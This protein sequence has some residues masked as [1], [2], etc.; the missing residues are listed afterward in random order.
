MPSGI[1]KPMREDAAAYVEH[2]YCMHMTPSRSLPDQLLSTADRA[3]R[4]LFAPARAARPAPGL[5]GAIPV[6]TERRLAAGLMRV[7]HAGEIAAQGLY[8]GQALV[9]R[10]PAIRQLLEKASRE[11]TDHLAWCE[12]R[13]REL[14]D[15]PSRL[16]PLWYAGSFA[17]GVAAGLA[18]DR[19]S[20]GFVAETERQVERHLDTHL[21]QLPATD[22]RSRAIIT[23]MRA[24]E[25][26]HGDLALESGGASLPIPVQ[27]LMQA[28]ARVMTTTSRWI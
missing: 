26:A 7:N 14:Q 1:A 18:N 8:H 10:D 11:E 25:I 24:D 6:E 9:A 12:E 13:L 19:V 5:P 21:E 17:I 16:D 4:A 22:L 20:L 15:R 2:I 28:T 23:Q 27:K 3:L